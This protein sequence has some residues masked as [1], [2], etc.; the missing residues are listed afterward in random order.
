M[1]ELS[2]PKYGIPQVCV[3][4][5]CLDQWKKIVCFHRNNRLDQSQHWILSFRLSKVALSMHLVIVKLPGCQLLT[6][7]PLTDL[8]SNPLSLFLF[9]AFHCFFYRLDDCRDVGWSWLHDHG[10][11]LRSSFKSI[12]MY[13]KRRLW[14]G[15]IWTR[16]DSKKI[17]FFKVV[18]RIETADYRVTKRKFW[19]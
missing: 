6:P 15:S 1:G 11:E 14:Q 19:R 4:W 2:E 17:T 7:S 10:R 5:R 8:F 13:G 18:S 9:S 16:I 12:H 3:V